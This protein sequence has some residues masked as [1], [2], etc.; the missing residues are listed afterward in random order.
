MV[1]TIRNY[2]TKKVNTG[3]FTN[4]YCEGGVG[5]TETIIFLHGSGPGANAESNW[6]RVLSHLSEKFHVIAP[7][8]IGFGATDLPENTNLTFW[9]WTTARVR[10][11]IEIMDY[12]NIEI[13]H[14][15]GNSMGGVVSLNALMYD[16]KRFN[17][18]VL[19]GSGGGAS[20]GGPT[21]EIVRMTQFY[22]DPTFQAFRNLI[23]WF[24]HDE[25]V[26]GERFEEIVEM[27][28]AN[29]MK[30]ETRA[31]YPTLFATMPHEIT[32]PPSALRRIQQHVLLIHGYEDRFV[33]YNSSMAILEHLPNAEL[34]LLKQCGHWVQIEK[35]DRFV[36]L[37]DQFFDQSKEVPQKI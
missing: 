15:V 32:I 11:I 27:R 28:F 22:R 23:S 8:M 2:E 1:T 7:D 19:M 16:A 21:P 25:S 36:Q 26:L 4:F 14:L 3:S 9:E 17:K 30:D 34:V 18:V 10:Q 37:V 20:T 6:S 29:M 35:F 13:A 31:I 12:N 24:M 5:N 33:P